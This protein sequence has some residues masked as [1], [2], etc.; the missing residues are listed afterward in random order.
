[1]QK[2]LDRLTIV[3]AGLA[4]VLFVLMPSSF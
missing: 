3:I 2:Q 4:G 1:V